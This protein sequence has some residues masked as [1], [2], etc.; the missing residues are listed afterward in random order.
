MEFHIQ[1]DAPKPRLMRPPGAGAPVSAP[2]A[3]AAGAPFSSMHAPGAQ[4]TKLEKARGVVHLG[5][6]VGLHL[7]VGE[8]HYDLESSS[9]SENVPVK[10]SLMLR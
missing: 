4:V 3:G 2:A 6:G 8:G 5:P 10:L 7:V 9:L 1:N